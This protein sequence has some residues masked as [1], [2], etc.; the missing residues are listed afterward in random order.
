MCSPSPS[1]AVIRGSEFLGKYAVIDG[2]RLCLHHSDESV[3]GEADWRFY[4][5]TP[6]SSDLVSV[7]E[8]LLLCSRNCNE[9]GQKIEVWAML[10]ALIRHYFFYDEWRG[11]ADLNKLYE[12]AFWFFK[13]GSDLSAEGKAKA[14]QI[15]YLPPNVWCETP[16]PIFVAD[17]LGPGMFAF[18]FHE[19][20]Q[21]DSRLLLSLGVY[22]AVWGAPCSRDYMQ[23]LRCFK[24]VAYDRSQ[25]GW[26]DPNEIDLCAVAQFYLGMMHLLG[27]GVERDP[28][29]AYVWFRVSTYP[30]KKNSWPR[31]ALGE[32]YC[33]ELKKVLSTEQ[34]DEGNRRVVE[35]ERVLEL[36]AF[37]G[38]L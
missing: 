31:C 24:M 35:L 21:P 2:F 38:F 23:A 13:L 9:Q 3:D 30:S 17:L 4:V 1:V 16:V 32:D 20:L 14:H 25:S 6:L 7:P 15:A 22:Y 18:C 36:G 34:I 8:L 37:S 10:N 19:R 12:V 28:L 33:A 29:E 27:F 26:L 11:R 5:L